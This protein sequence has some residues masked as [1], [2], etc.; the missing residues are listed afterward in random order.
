MRRPRTIAAI[1]GTGTRDITIITARTTDARNT[2]NART[3]GS[4][5][6]LERTR[7]WNARGTGTHAALERTRH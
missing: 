6:G 2:G 5:A 7:D 3:T 4:H 1:T